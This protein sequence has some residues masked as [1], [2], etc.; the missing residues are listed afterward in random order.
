M[1]K[2]SARTLLVK[3]VLM[4]A[5][6]VAREDVLGSGLWLALSDVMSPIA[7]L[8]SCVA[9]WPALCLKPQP[10]MNASTVKIIMSTNTARR[11]RSSRDKRRPAWG[12]R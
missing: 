8:L 12:Q 1:Q 9:A 6:K 4:L 3:T 2:S 7:G 10:A 11:R 5:A